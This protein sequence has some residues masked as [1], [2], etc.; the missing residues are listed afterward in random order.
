MKLCARSFGLTLGLAILALGGLAYR[1]L[2][3]LT[4]LGWDSY[5]M[6]ASAKIGSL[7]DLAGVFTE[8][9][10][11]GRYPDGHFY[12]PLT[13][14]SLAL[15]HLLYGLD[16]R[17]YHATDLALLMLNALA[18]GYLGRR[19]YAR[20]VG[21]LSGCSGTRGSGGQQGG[22]RARLAGGVAAL[23]FLL[24]PIQ[25]ELL[26]V[27]ARRADALCLAFGLLALLAL[28]ERAGGPR[29]LLVGAL[30]CAAAASKES[31]AILAPLIFAWLWLFSSS[32]GAPRWK[33][34]ARGSLPAFIG[35]A[36]FVG[37][38]ALVLRGLG[39]HAESSLGG[40]GASAA[41]IEPYLL[42]VLYP[43]PFAG[44][45][46]RARLGV[47]V[48]AS[49]LALSVSWLAFGARRVTAA[50]PGAAAQEPG[51][52][53]AGAREALLFLLVWSALLLAISSLSGRVHD[54]YAMLFVAPFALAL[55]G[56]LA[57]AFELA[58]AGRRATALTLGALPLATA[59]A[60]LANSPLNPVSTL[61]RDDRWPLASALTESLL[62][63]AVELVDHARPGEDLLLDHWIPLLAPPEGGHG[64]RSAAVLAPYSVEAY[65][66]LVRPER[67]L[68]VRAA[69]PGLPAPPAGLLRI[70][71][72]SE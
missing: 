25:L 43:Q 29:Q 19:L 49:L 72:T 27:T 67:A 35:L 39:G 30:A 18:L 1:G 52:E 48:F 37:A 58:R 28:R 51:G 13:N 63:R 10:M 38:R 60:L 65:L 22:T 4:L 70:R 7:S 59:L 5:P 46:Q 14:L 34:A 50:E 40:L 9:L 11:D 44:V 71:L 31:G 26:P 33:Q 8:E 42:R 56:A 54:W 55:G 21:R 62:A 6:I 15:D 45:D 66:E 47:L 24:H 64:V 53:R 23:S 20:P 32:R 57:L 17:G 61:A 36:L 2:F 69:A 12:R 3:E 16:A 41:L 68:Q